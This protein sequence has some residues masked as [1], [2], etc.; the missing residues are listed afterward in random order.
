[1]RGVFR[2]RY[3]KP[4]PSYKT[5]SKSDKYL[6]VVI[7][8]SSVGAGFE[9]LDLGGNVLFALFIGEPDGLV[10]LR[11]GRP[12]LCL[13]CWLEYGILPDGSVGVSVDLLDVGR[14]NVVGEVG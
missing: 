1:M 14:S 6:L 11:L 9:S 7:V 8:S 2:V 12:V 13:V 3:N 4:S 5:V 10:F